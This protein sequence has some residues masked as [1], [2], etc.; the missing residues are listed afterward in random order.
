I[1]DI[2]AYEAGG[3][4][5][6]GANQPPVAA[7]T[8]SSASGNAPLLVNFSSA[9]SHDPDGSI[10]TYRWTFGDGAA[11]TG[12]TASHTYSTAGAFTATLTV[13]DDKGASASVSRTITTTQ[14]P[15][16]PAAPVLSGSVSGT[17]ITLSW[18][19]P[20]G[21]VT[22]YRL[23]RRAN[24]GNWRLLANT[25]QRTYSET[26]TRGTWTYRVR[27]FN[28]AGNSPWSAA[29]TLRTR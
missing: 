27:A 24:N 20:R 23:E 14:Q 3:G 4:T 6:P 1:L 19:A 28:P 7:M 15:A 10:A 11:A 16:V 21:V 29:V 9:G 5:A 17:R 22:G 12:V 8:V 18:T 13:T 2:G 25:S 26:R